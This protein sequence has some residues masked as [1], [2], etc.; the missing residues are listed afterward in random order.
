MGF[1]YKKQPVKAVVTHPIRTFGTNYQ[2]TTGR[3]LL[4]IVAVHCVRA[5]Q[6][7]AYSFAVGKVEDATPPTD[8][9]ST[10]G[11]YN[12]DSNPD[13]AL[14]TLVFAV[15]N[16]YYYVLQL[17]VDALGSTGV[18]DDWTEVEL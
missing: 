17:Q 7:N 2:N 13:D 8:A 14:F 15:P 11:L 4:V 1:K 12:E 3:P 6:V 9:V 16:G 18:I 5:N 10:G